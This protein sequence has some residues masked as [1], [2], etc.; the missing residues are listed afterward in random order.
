MI[1]ILYTRKIFCKDLIEFLQ[2]LHLPCV[3][4][5]IF[6]VEDGDLSEIV[7]TAFHKTN[8]VISFSPTNESVCLCNAH[9]IIKNSI[10]NEFSTSQST[11]HK[12]GA[13]HEKKLVKTLV[14]YNELDKV[15][16]HYLST[17]STFYLNF[18]R[19]NLAQYHMLNKFKI[20]YTSRI[21]EIIHTDE[22][23]LFVDTKVNLKKM[24]LTKSMRVGL[25]K[26][27]PYVIKNQ[28][29]SYDGV[30]YRM[31]KQITEGY[32][33]EIFEVD[34]SDYKKNPWDYVKKLV[35]DQVIDVGICSM[36]MNVN[37]LSFLEGTKPYTEICLT[38]LVPRPQLMD[39]SVYLYLPLKVHVWMCYI[40]SIIFAIL[41]I[42]YVSDAANR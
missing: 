25:F 16:L 10:N 27:P 36:F 33:I 15:D 21:S 28:D 38:F 39:F 7:I 2:K 12:C 34:T 4:C 8:S 37:D 11:L 5:W 17:I 40:F 31:L 1:L 13:L 26:N 42:F 30:E 19:I 24:F 41:A 3:K 18:I 32:K 9:V 29:G 35:N 23:H 20:E 14:F 22:E 6:Y